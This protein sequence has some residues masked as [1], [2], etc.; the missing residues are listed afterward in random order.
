VETIRNESLKYCVGFTTLIALA[1]LY[2]GIWSFDS[3]IPPDATL[4]SSMKPVL[5]L[6]CAIYFAGAILSTSLTTR[7]TQLASWT[8]CI[9]VWAGILVIISSYSNPFGVL[10]FLLP[11][12][13]SAFLFD[14]KRMA[15]FIG[16]ILFSFMVAN[17]LYLHSAFPF[18]E[19]IVPWIIVLSISTFILLTINPLFSII[20]WYEKK[21]VTAH[22]NEQ[23]IKDNEII[24]ERL[25]RSLNE[26]Q[27]Y[28][29]S[30]NDLLIKARDE[31]E[32]AK[33][34]KQV[35]VQ[36][37]SHELRTPLNLIIGFSE[38]M[39]HTPLIYGNINWTPELKGDIECIFQNSQHLKSLI[40]DVLELAA[41]EHKK[42][43]IEPAVVD[44]RALILEVILVME[45]AYQSKGLSLEKDL[46]DEP[47]M[48]HADGVRI[49]QVLLNL[50]YNA[51]KYTSRGGVVISARRID[52]MARVSVQ[53]TGKGI[54]ED[55]LEK[56]FDAFYQ[57]DKSNNREDSG[58]GLGLSISKQLIELHGGEM[59]ISSILNKGTTVFFTVPNAESGFEP[60]S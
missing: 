13:F 20:D 52:Q 40:D 23:I 46:L 2:A 3:G 37:V 50:L 53:D 19:W 18:S 44:L 58:T 27:K 26:T 14:W 28:L 8:L 49:K 59:K 33:N 48:V 41:L 32:T 57:V 10:G 45:V 11:I 1:L 15:I 35:F 42:Y 29:R 54:P 17:M 31:A 25:V 51:L 43:E 39:I 47:L 22:Q 30:T 9:F 16:L 38:T 4:I 34:A 5:W 55:A 36:T 60:T 21:Y 56:V 24:L 12:L 7:S 6:A